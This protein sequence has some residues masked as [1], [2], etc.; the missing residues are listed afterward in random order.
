MAFEKWKTYGQLL[1]QYIFIRT[2]KQKTVKGNLVLLRFRNK[3]WRM[4]VSGL[5]V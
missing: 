3:K 1:L 2:V 4:S 5:Y